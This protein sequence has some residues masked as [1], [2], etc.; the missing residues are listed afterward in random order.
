MI[1]FINPYEL[2][3]KG[4]YQEATD[5]GGSEETFTWATK[6]GAQYENM[7]MSKLAS[8]RTDEKYEAHQQISETRATFKV[9]KQNRVF[10]PKGRLEIVEDGSTNYYYITGIRPFKGF[11]NILMIDAEIKDNQS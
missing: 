2:N 9:M 4:N 8:M 6:T 3:V 1:G 10:F 5:A 7:A 11:S